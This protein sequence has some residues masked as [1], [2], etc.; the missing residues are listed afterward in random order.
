MMYKSGL[1]LL[2]LLMTSCSTFTGKSG[3][4]VEVPEV[5]REFRAAWIATVVN[6]DW[7]SRSGLSTE[8]QKNELVHMLDTC[9]DMKMNAVLFQVRTMCDALYDSDLE[10]WAEWLTGEMGK[11][12]ERGRSCPDKRTA[13]A[14]LAALPLPEVY[15]IFT[16]T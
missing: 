12:P 1:L 13:E 10:P 3:Q 15:A 11:A 7:P 4:I 5:Q 14:W 8:E 9:Q 6:I 2:T 16:P